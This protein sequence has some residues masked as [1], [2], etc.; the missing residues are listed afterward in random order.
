[1]PQPAQWG[2]L[3][4]WPPRS[5][6][7]LLTPYQASGEKREGAFYLWTRAEVEATLGNK[8]LAEVFCHH[9]YIKDNGNTDLSPM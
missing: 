2:M 7:P 5:P 9:Y 1:M 8:Q 6:V 3:R 4:P